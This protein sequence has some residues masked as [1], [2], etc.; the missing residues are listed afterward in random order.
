M[1]ESDVRVPAKY[2]Y[3]RVIVPLDHTVG[4]MILT[5]PIVNEQ[6]IASPGSNPTTFVTILTAQSNTIKYSLTGR[7]FPESPERQEFPELVAN[8]VLGHCLSGT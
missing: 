8:L 5:A 7:V 1:L 3:R 4:C 6:E 2:S